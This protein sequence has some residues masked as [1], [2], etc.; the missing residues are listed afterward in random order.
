M[1]K[2]G[3]WYIEKCSFKMEESIVCLETQGNGPVR[4]VEQWCNEIK[5]NWWSGI[6]KNVTW[7]GV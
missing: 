3:T 1:F 4:K 6:F 5:K 2:E 7:N